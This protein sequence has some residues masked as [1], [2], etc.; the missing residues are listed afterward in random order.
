MTYLRPAVIA[1]LP[2]HFFQKAAFPYPLIKNKDKIPFTKTSLFKKNGQNTL[3]LFPENSD[4]PKPW[5]PCAGAA[6]R[7]PPP[8]LPC[9]KGAGCQR[10]TERLSARLASHKS[11]VVSTLY[12][13]FPI[14][15]IESLLSYPLR[16]FVTPPLTIRGGMGWGVPPP[17]TI[18]RKKRQK[19]K[20]DRVL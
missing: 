5:L 13:A 2:L 20:G 17:L 18:R 12:A 15:P 19:R 1:T 16:H 10:L 11:P 6:A 7:P 8:W 9:A 3:R 4:T 14:F